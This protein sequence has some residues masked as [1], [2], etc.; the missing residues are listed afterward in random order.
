MYY[1]ILVDT[2]DFSVLLIRG[3][4]VASVVHKGHTA[5]QSD[6]E[7][8]F[9]KLGGVRVKCCKAISIADFFFKTLKI[10]PYIWQKSKPL[11]S[12]AEKMQPMPFF[13]KLSFR[14]WEKASW[15]TQP[16]TDQWKLWNKWH[17]S[18]VQSLLIG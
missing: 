14:I 17:A 7:M 3:S 16:P 6:A 10:I 8:W 4:I 9:Y 15:G 12:E 18:D 2:Q 11:A 13:M 1:I 5:N